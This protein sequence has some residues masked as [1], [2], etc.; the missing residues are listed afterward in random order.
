MIEEGMREQC[1]DLVMVIE[2]HCAM[3]MKEK[4]F[5]N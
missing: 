4:R 3:K 2:E 5:V 1:S